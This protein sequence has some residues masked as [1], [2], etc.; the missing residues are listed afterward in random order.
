[1]DIKT[2]V[3]LWESGLLQP[4]ATSAHIDLPTQTDQWN[5]VYMILSFRS[6]VTS[7]GTISYLIK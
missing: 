6:S 2:F 4:G 7:G 3:I 1:V 5:F